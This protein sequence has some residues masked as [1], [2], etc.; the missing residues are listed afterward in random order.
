MPDDR[1]KRLIREDFEHALR[2]IG[3]YIDVTVEDL[4][5][6]T[7]RAEKHAALRA[8]EAKKVSTV[9]TNPVHTVRPDTTL[10]QASARLLANRVSGLAVVD[11]A[12]RLVGII[13]EAD[14]LRAV[15]VRVHHPSQ[16][17]WQTL[18]SL[19]THAETLHEP[20]G[21]VA[22]LMITDVVTARP[23]ETLFDVVEKM[24]KHRIKRIVVTDDAHHP[25]GMV[26]R[27]DLVRVFFERFKGAAQSS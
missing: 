17:L 7:S 25:V 1:H 10:A 8:K 18:E 14:F 15:G 27:S 26:T 12:N 22:D 5:D 16:T 13:T 6:I 23:E 20:D 24:K 9:M 19:F 3:S 4:M 11:E 2:E 21:T